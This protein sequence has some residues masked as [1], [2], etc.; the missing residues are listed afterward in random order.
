MS[1]QLHTPAALPPGKESRVPM[2]KEVGWASEPIWTTWRSEN[3]CLIG[4]S[5]SDPSVVQPVYRE[6]TI[7]TL[8]IMVFKTL[9]HFSK[10]HYTLDNLFATGFINA[11]LNEFNRGFS[12][13][14]TECNWNFKHSWVQLIWF[15]LSITHP[16]MH[17]THDSLGYRPLQ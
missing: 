7:K 17:N 12:V 4:D 5:N 15:S 3:S 11:R 8:K 2:G 13:E 6:C 16:Y 1:G 9:L 14:C 10:M